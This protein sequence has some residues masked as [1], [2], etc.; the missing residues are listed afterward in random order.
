MDDFKTKQVV[1]T[2]STLPPQGRIFPQEEVIP[3]SG[4]KKFYRNNK[5]YVWAILAA[6]VIISVLGFL[7]FHK[8]PASPT[9]EANVN[10]SIDL[11]ETLPS[12]GDFIF[13]VK[14]ENR[15]SAKLVNMNLEV[16]YPEGVEYLSSSPS[17]KDGSGSSPVCSSR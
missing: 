2:P 1:S 9:K 6:L 10:L 16:V 8:S 4:F 13:R 11:P 3:A 7:A 15:D 17:S 14:V 12:S 5:W